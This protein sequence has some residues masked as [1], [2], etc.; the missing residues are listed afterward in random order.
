MVHELLEAIKENIKNYVTHRLFIVT[1]LAIFMFG[2]LI[3]RLFRLQIVE[4]EEHLKNFTYKIERSLAINASRGN[5]YDRNGNLLA[6]NKLVYSVT[7][8]NSSELTARS[9]E[10]DVSENQLKNQIVYETIHILEEHGDSIMNNF[11]IIL[12]S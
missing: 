12:N 4:G 2:I 5:I 11:T 6:Y 1:L 9:K 7:F 3:V 10:L 8:G